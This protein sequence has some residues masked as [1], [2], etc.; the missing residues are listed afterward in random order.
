MG[1]LPEWLSVEHN[2][3]LAA[4]GEQPDS[5]DVVVFTD[6]FHRDYDIGAKGISKDNTVILS[7]S[8]LNCEREYPLRYVREVFYG[9]SAEHIDTNIAERELPPSL[10]DVDD[11]LLDGID[12]AEEMLDYL[13]GNE[14]PE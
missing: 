14:H 7:D 13:Q 6:D 2:T 1:E 9:V 12:A 8:S 10:V 4:D 3:L 11:D 5:C